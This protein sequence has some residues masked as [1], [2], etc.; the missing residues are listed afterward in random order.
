MLSHTW[1][2]T[3]RHTTTL[4]PTIRKS[5]H[6]HTHTWDGLLYW[7]C[8]A[9]VQVLVGFADKLRLMTI[10]MEDLKTVKEFG[11]KVGWGRTWCTCHAH[12]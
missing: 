11:I 6:T 4:T 7:E 9:Y 1:T 2:Y 12:G 3:R 8:G 10:L 5:A